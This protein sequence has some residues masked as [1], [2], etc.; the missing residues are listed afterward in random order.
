MKLCDVIDGRGRTAR[1]GPA[2]PAIVVSIAYDSRKAAAGCLFF[3]LPGEKVD[4]IQFV[5][6]A[7]ARGAAAHG[8]SQGRARRKFRRTSPGSNW[9]P[10]RSGGHWRVLRANFYGR[11]A[12]ALKLVGVTGT[13]GKT[14]TAFLGRF[15]SARGRVTRPG[16]SAPP[17]IALR[18]AAARAQTPRPNRSTCSRCSPKFATP[19]ARTRC[20]R[21][22]LTRWP[23]IAVGL[24]FR[25]G[26]FHEFDARPSRLPQDIRGIFRRQAAAF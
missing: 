10:G 20:W 19:A 11:P 26:D 14:T 5:S 21:R 4:G 25:G 9:R 16:W 15:D 24:P 2:D 8:Q 12:D 1:S 13:N 23:W 22:V 18:R 17:A 6:D 7:I 3:A